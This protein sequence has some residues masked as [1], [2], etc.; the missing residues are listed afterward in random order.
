VDERKRAELLRETLKE[1]LDDDDTQ[2]AIYE[3]VAK[4]WPRRYALGSLCELEMIER[5]FKGKK[6]ISVQ[7]L[8]DDWPAYRLDEK[9]LPLAGSHTG[10]LLEGELFL[11]EKGNYK[12][13][14]HGRGVRSVRSWISGQFAL[15]R[16]CR[17]PWI[18]TC[19]DD[20]T[21]PVLHSE[22]FVRRYFFAGMEWDNGPNRLIEKTY[23]NLDTRRVFLSFSPP[24]KSADDE[25][26]CEQ[27]WDHYA[28]WVEATAERR[29]PHLGDVLLGRVE[30][31]LLLGK[32]PG[33]RRQP[34]HQPRRAHK[35][36]RI[37]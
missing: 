27:A 18:K 24:G 8:E 36:E 21:L 22:E 35:L 14:K 2:W 28:A 34:V 4:R 31:E 25:G 7:V 37:K 11:I 29:Q 19:R 23:F 15:M 12:L 17:K 30:D 5:C 20:P 9:N 6:P 32:R 16:G 26:K 1:R 3:R 10:Q 13:P 33:L